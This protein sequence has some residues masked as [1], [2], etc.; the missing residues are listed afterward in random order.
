[1]TKNM[2]EE[3]FNLIGRYQVKRYLSEGGMQEVYLAV[4]KVFNRPVALKTPKN[5]SA[6]KRFQRSAVVSA[7][8][9]H[10]NIA[11]TLDYF[12]EEG[13]EYLVEEYI[14]GNN[15]S[16]ML[17]NTYVLLDPHLAAHLF[18]HLAKGVAASHHAGVFHRD[19]KPSNIM[20][21]KDP[22]LK[23]IKITDFGIAKLAEE[24]IIAGIE[25]GDE[26]ITSSKTVVGALPYM[27][28]EMVD[29]PREAGTAADIWAL[30]AILY[31]ALTGKPPFGTGLSAVTRILQ[32]P[33]PAMPDT[34]EFRRPQ[35]SHLNAQLWSLMSDC[36]D[37]DPDQRP[38]AD[39]LVGYCSSLCYSVQPREFG[40]VK[41]FDEHYGK[42]GF[43][44]AAGGPDIF[45]HAG[46][47]YGSVPEAGVTVNF[48][49][50]P[51]RPKPRAFPIL[52]LQA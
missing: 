4:D 48:A 23:T 9:N 18:H 52:P 26:S 30:G 46:S 22:S 37:K 11:K 13:A 12:E 47:V 24:E 40:T 15:L 28:P 29:R 1:M 17:A 20:V 49:S 3:N 5:S 41:S 21:S 10:S 31:H 35:F 43:I 33:V 51:G 34:I 27:A 42:W 45:F 19:L 50:Y 14:K 7:R 16:E 8:V 25:G 36:L 32:E 44:A 6:E 39:D 38:T 2:L